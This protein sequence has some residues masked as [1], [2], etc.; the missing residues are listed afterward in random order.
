MITRNNELDGSKEL[1]RARL[2]LEYDGEVW[3]TDTERGT[4]DVDA[5]LVDSLEVKPQAPQAVVI[6]GFYDVPD[7][8]GESV[9]T[10]CSADGECSESCDACAVVQQCGSAN[11][12]IIDC[13]ATH[14]GKGASRYLRFATV[15][16]VERLRRGVVEDNG[17]IVVPAESEAD[18]N[19]KRL[20]RYEAWS[21][22]LSELTRER[23]DELEKEADAKEEARR[24]KKA[25]EAL[26]RRYQELILRGPDEFQLDDAPL[27]TIAENWREL[28][29]AKLRDEIGDATFAVV[30]ENFRTLGQISDWMGADPRSK[31]KGLTEKRVDAISDALEKFYAE[32]ERAEFARADAI[33]AEREAA[34]RDAEA[35]ETPLDEHEIA[36]ARLA[37]EAIN[38]AIERD[39]WEGF[40][41]DWFLDVS[42]QFEDDEESL[43]RAQ[44]DGLCNIY[45]EFQRR[46]KTEAVAR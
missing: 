39:V 8:T 44:F 23:N 7:E 33:A 22:R 35:D 37:V 17:E 29:V 40:D 10:V 11:C 6:G 15:D 5:A 24:A 30:E 38:E 14:Y 43:T 18:E 25:A 1:E 3:F 42:T 27:L 9:L 16:D 20:A 46:E 45:N 13:G 34:R 4:V 12:P 41:A 32:E 21:R 31:I 28:P 2:F 26:E 36:A 19:A